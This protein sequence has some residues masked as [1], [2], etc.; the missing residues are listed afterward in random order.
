MNAI[1]SDDEQ[2]SL[3]LTERTCLSTY[4]GYLRINS[5]QR[6]FYDFIICGLSERVLMA[7]WRDLLCSN[8]YR[9]RAVCGYIRS[10]G[11]SAYLRN[12]NEI[13]NFVKL[14]TVVCF[15]IFL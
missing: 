15:N 4:S 6:V 3:L 5:Q 8:Y 12:K 1:Y 2:H 10:G 9:P 7:I 13:Q 11:L 14:I